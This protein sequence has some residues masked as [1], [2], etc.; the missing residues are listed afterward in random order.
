[1]A[2]LL[3]KTDD[4]FGMQVSNEKGL[5]IQMDAS[6]DLGGKDT[7]MRPMEVLASSLA[8]CISV[9]VILI[10]RK[11]RIELDHYLVTIDTQ[12]AE[13]VPAPFEKIH[14]TF[15]F[16]RNVDPAKA[17]RAVKLAKDKYCSVSASL[18]ETIQITHELKFV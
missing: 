7:G 10:L 16:S 1:M 15:E 3:K 13:G 2:L 18:N 12:R 5:A 17:D 9:D 4:A 14:L 11:Q 6:T 8:G